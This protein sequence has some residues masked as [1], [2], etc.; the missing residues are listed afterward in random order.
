MASDGDLFGPVSTG[1][2]PPRPPPPAS[3]Q[4]TP[5]ATASPAKSAFDD[6]NDSIRM[7]LGGSPAHPQQQQQPPQPQQPVLQQNVAPPQPAAFGAFD[8]AGQPAGNI[9]PN[10]GFPGGV[11]GFGSPAK[12]GVPMAGKLE[13]ENCWEKNFKNGGKI[14]KKI[15]FTIL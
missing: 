13:K 5:A 14:K 10:M 2:P 11:P 7:A 3:G 15:F 12:Q 4:S 6:L 8:M 1:P 9:I